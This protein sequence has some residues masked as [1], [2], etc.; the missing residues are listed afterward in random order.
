LAQFYSEIGDMLKANN[1]INQSC[2]RLGNN[3]PE[4]IRTFSTCTE[5][6]RKIGYLAKAKETLELTR[7]SIDSYDSNT[8]LYLLPVLAQNYAVDGNALKARTLIEEFFK[9]LSNLPPEAHTEV[10][11][12]YA[13]ACIK[14]YEPEELLKKLIDNWLKLIGPECLVLDDLFLLRRC[15]A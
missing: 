10:N 4:S 6:W 12:N 11:P 3:S 9:G 15:M 7:K 2:N 8:R 13:D 5:A 1:F 14:I